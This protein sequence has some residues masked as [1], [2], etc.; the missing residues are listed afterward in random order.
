[1]F[2]SSYFVDLG[3]VEAETKGILL[4]GKEDVQQAGY[5]IVQGLSDED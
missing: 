3:S 2:N 1:M 5:F 4:D